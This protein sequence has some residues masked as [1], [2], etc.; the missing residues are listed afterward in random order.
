MRMIGLFYGICVIVR[1]GLIIGGTCAWF[2]EYKRKQDAFAKGEDYFY[3][4]YNPQEY[5]ATVKKC[6]V[7]I[8]LGLFIPF[9]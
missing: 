5:S 4:H 1:L 6:I 7:A 2:S 8:A 9:P 3:E